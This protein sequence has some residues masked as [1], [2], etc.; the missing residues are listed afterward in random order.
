[1]EADISIWRKPGHFYF[2]LTPRRLSCPARVVNSLHVYQGGLDANNILC[3]AVPFRV[4][5]PR[6]EV[7]KLRRG[8]PSPSFCCI[9]FW[10]NPLR[11]VHFF[12]IARQLRSFGHANCTV[13]R[14]TL[15]FV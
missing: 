5:F 1:M 15:G 10:N 6:T 8:W 11:K 7:T 13:L 14:M 9:D 12:A 4:S 3:L 2:A